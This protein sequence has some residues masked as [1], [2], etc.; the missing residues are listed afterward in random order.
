M[1]MTR[2]SHSAP[3]GSEPRADFLSFYKNMI[4][5]IHSKRHSTERRFWFL[6]GQVR[7][8]L[9][10]LRLEI[11]LSMSLCESS[12]KLPTGIFK[13]EIFKCRHGVVR[14]YVLSSYVRF[15]VQVESSA[16]IQLLTMSMERWAE[17]S[18][19]ASEPTGWTGRPTASAS[20][21]SAWPG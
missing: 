21:S 12:R 15:H 14:L 2:Q 1:C 18:L 19:P 4:V 16:K 13:K 7:R 11:L 17:L 3:A 8:N 6:L 10:P 20:R 9:Y 5:K